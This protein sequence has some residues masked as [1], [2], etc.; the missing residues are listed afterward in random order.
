MQF[1][2]VFINFFGGIY[3]DGILS[4]RD[5]GTRIF[6]GTY[7]SIQNGLPETETSTH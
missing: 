4:G 7:N 5:F 6:P 2:R 1:K 3:M